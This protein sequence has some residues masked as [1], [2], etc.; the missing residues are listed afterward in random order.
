MTFPFIRIHKCYTI[1]ASDSSK[2]QSLQFLSTKN[3]QMFFQLCP[4][5]W[6]CQHA[7]YKIQHHQLS[8]LWKLLV[9]DLWNCQDLLLCFLQ[10]HG[11][12]GFFSGIIITFA[13]EE[14]CLYFGV[15]TLILH[16]RIWN[17]PFTTC[18]ESSTTCIESSW[19]YV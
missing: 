8:F 5:V 18:T 3:I 16:G 2:K 12:I 1:K 15:T 14:M 13:A 19:N 11:N 6:D 10:E 9:S 4:A 7:L 17:H